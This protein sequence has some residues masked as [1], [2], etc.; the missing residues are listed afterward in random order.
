MSEAAAGRPRHTVVG[1]GPVATEA[2]LW[3]SVTSETPVQ[4]AL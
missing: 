4:S 1:G 3:T 2:P